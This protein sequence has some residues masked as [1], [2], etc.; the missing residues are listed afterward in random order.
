LLGGPA[1]AVDIEWVTVGDPGNP[2]DTDPSTYRCGPS[3]DQPCGAVAYTYRISKYEI[4]NVQYAEFLNAVAATDTYGL[5]NASMGSP[6]YFYFGGI[7][8]S[9]S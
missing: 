8:Q 6:E 2:A 4:T 7:T 9:G 1:Q 5:Y 3:M